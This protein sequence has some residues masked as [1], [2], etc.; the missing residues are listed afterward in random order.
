MVD[1]KEN[2]VNEEEA[3][4][5]AENQEQQTENK[6]NETDKAVN[7]EVAGETKEKDEED[8]KSKKKEAKKKKSKKKDKKEEE[9]EALNEKLEVMNDK[10][11]RLSAEF[12]NYRRRTLK[13]KT[14]LLKTAGGDAISDMLP[15]VDDFERALGSMENAEDVKA[16]KDGVMLIYNKF[17]EFMKSKGIQE[18]DALHQEFDTDFHEALTKI[19]APDEKLKGKVVDVIQKGYRIDEKVIR[20][21]KVVIGE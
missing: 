8:K 14:E 16:V 11:I 9:I 15:V 7:D 18:I 17:K 3:K 21:A 1:K 4:K 19:P 2:V 6:A 5:Q 10:Y 13:E 20:F 12:D